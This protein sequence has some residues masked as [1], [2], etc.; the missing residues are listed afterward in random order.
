MKLSIQERVIISNQLL[1]LEKLNPEE[2]QSYRKHRTAIECGYTLHYGWIA[3]H[4]WDEM[5][6]EDSQE[7]L[8]ILELHRIINFSLSRDENAPEDLIQKAR[9]KGFDG[10]NESQQFSYATYFVVDL[11]RYQELVKHQEFPNLNSHAPMLGRYRKMVERWK[12]LGSPVNLN[13]EQTREILGV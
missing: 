1:I 4:F 3:E 5:P 2:A 11:G 13:L 8:N 7:V 10:N 6:E 9:F 12:E